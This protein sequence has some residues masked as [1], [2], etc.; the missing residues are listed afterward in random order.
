[1]SCG[2]HSGLETAANDPVTEKG[3]I[4]TSIYSDIAFLVADSLLRPLL[5]QSYWT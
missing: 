2:L 3:H 1:M 4:D 5:I